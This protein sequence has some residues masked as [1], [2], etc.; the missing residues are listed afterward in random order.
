MG[1]VSCLGNQL[2]QVSTALRAGRSGIVFVDEYAQLG[3]RSHVAGIP[4]V[5]DLPTIDRKLR[6]FMGGGAQH[7]YHA[8]CRAVDD[9]R[10]TTHEIAHPRTGLIVG[11]AIGSMRDQIE[12]VD[13]LRRRGVSK[14]PPYQVPR[15]MA[16][17]ASAT[18]ATAFGVQG[19]SYSMVSACATS[20]HCIGQGMDLIAAGKQDRVFVGGAEAVCWT[21]T[22]SFDAMG[23]LSSARNDAPQKASRPYDSGRDG[24]AISGGAGILVLE[25]LEQARARGAPIY[26]EMVGYG[27]N[28]D[29]F[30]MVMPSP[31]GAARVMRLALA[32]AGVSVDYVNTHATSTP[33]GDISEVQAMRQVFG[34]RMP[35]FSSTKSL[36][37]HAIGAAAVHEAIYSL[38]MLR[39]GFIAGSANVDT[40]DPQLVGLPLVR[41]SV[42]AEID[43]VMSNSFGFGGTNASLMFRRFVP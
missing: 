7:A 22:V 27:A 43:V 2:D 34:E 9:A 30:D 37:G 4:D 20:A 36:T 33:L 21:T 41:N 13:I 25:E 15:I 3:F 39:D 8:M 35:H 5:R 42:V 6:R 28:S 26:A 16:S 40:L 38:L 1:I 29:G 18:L 24:F 17:T 12:S 31:D 11:S 14:I 10:L 19:V 32:Q 23:V